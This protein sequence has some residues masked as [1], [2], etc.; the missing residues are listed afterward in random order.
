MF[1]KRIFSPQKFI[2][3]GLLDQYLLLIFVIFFPSLY[4]LK[5]LPRL[6]M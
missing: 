2:S 5:Q 1:I 6:E 3:G 4:S